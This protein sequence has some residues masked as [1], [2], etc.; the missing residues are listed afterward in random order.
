MDYENTQKILSCP[1]KEGEK[2]TLFQGLTMMVNHKQWY[3]IIVFFDHVS[4]LYLL[5]GMKKHD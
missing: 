3:T 1:Q 2:I 5:L 4:S